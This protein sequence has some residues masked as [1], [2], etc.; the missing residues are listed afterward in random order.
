MSK[1]ETMLVAIPEAAKVLGVSKKEVQDMVGAGILK[2]FTTGSQSY[3][4]RA[5]IL[6]L[7]G[8]TAAEENNSQIPENKH[9]YLSPEELSSVL[10]NDDNGQQDIMKAGASDMT[11]FTGSI[12]ELKDG[13]FMVQINL[14]KKADG[15]RNRE[16][17][18]F[19]SKMEAQDYLNHRLYE[20]NGIMP[21]QA[22]LPIQPVQISPSGE[23]SGSDAIFRSYTT[24]T[25]EEY[26]LGV[27][28]EGVGVA[29]SRTL[30]GYRMGLQPVAEIIGKMPMVAITRKDINKVFSI[31]CPKYVK[32]N[33]DRS[34]KILKLIMEQAYDDG[35]IPTNPMKKMKCPKST[36]PVELNDRNAIYSAEDIAYLFR[37]SR[38]YNIELYTMFVLL[39][40]TG[41]RP[42]E[43]RALEW[44]SFSPIEKTIKVKQAATFDFEDFSSLMKKPTARPIIATTK[45]AYGVR[46]LRLSDLAV[47]A[48]LEWKAYK[49][50]SRN[51]F[52]ATSEYIFS[53]REGDF[54]SETACKSMLQRYR[55]RYDEDNQIGVKLYKFRHTMCTRLVM[56][57]QP[58]PVIQRVLGDNTP[59]MILRV[60]SHVNSQM[61]M[62]SV[63]SFYDGLNEQHSIL[64]TAI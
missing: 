19:R 16:S 58:V 9:G 7:A 4:T 33:I 5:S 60:Y 45:S 43:M 18:S 12:S 30:E 11:M 56:D 23:I 63:G 50:K 38:E 13:R 21:P 51:R 61:A 32:S 29:T 40:S 35:H 41:M 1:K 39:E 53:N 10:T 36:K 62:N 57:N 52:T 64:E 20:L 48:L 59:E 25:F 27:L 8:V 55:K 28:N 37:T 42:G 17:K 24:L 49:S 46:T 34:F 3:V 47:E 44:S 31:L 22:V 6:A 26:A 54:K 15:S 14:G 2:G